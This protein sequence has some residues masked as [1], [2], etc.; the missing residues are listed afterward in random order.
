MLWPLARRIAKKYLDEGEELAEWVSD[1]DPQ[2]N[3]PEDGML[4]WLYR[5]A[6]F[7]W[8]EYVL[9]P[10]SRT[11]YPAVLFEAVARLPTRLREEAYGIFQ[12]LDQK[13]SI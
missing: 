10:A 11:L 8:T 4:G 13:S 3:I 5:H 1:L 7:R 12:Q 9:G 2:F 6:G